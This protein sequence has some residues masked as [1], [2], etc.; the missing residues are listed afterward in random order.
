MQKYAL[1]EKRKLIIKPVVNKT[2]LQW[3]AEAKITFIR[4]LS[5][6]T[7]FLEEIIT[8]RI[9]VQE[10]KTMRQRLCK[11]AVRQ[12]TQ[13]NSKAHNYAEVTVISVLG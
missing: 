10:K 9:I 5:I 11:D 7:G 12:K 13:A 2:R 8:V 4:L 1:P 6:S 3:D